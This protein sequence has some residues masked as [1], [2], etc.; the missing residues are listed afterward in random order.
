MYGHDEINIGD[1]KLVLIEFNG[2]VSFWHEA[3]WLDATRQKRKTISTSLILIVKSK[4][5]DGR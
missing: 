5:I 2:D 4:Y 1:Y 3:K